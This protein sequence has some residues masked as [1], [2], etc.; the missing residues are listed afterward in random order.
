MHQSCIYLGEDKYSLDGRLRKPQKHQQLLKVAS[1]NVFII[2]QKT[3]TEGASQ[4]QGIKEG[5]DRKEGK[6]I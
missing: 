1:R 2:S 4:P 5:G 3:V 6:E